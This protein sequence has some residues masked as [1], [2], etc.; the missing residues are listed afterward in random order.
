[1][2]LNYH[3]PNTEYTVNNCI[4]TTFQSSFEYGYHSLFLSIISVICTCI[5]IDLDVYIGDKLDDITITCL[6]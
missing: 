3:L 5:V 6:Q 2:D 1:M 4:I